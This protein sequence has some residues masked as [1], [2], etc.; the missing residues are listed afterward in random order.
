M[1]N[2]RRNGLLRSLKGFMLKRMHNMITCKEFEDF[3][4][5]YFEGELSDKQ[6][7]VFELHL[8]LC[9]ECREYLAAYKRTQEITAT[10]LASPKSPVP[11]DVP[12]DLIKAILEAR[13]H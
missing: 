9:R 4:Q 11:D 1:N 8:R 6:R 2:L 12:E 7:S 3:V 13:K 10:V 5:L